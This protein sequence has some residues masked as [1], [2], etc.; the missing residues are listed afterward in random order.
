MLDSR[1]QMPPDARMLGLPGATLVCCTAGHDPAALERA[2][3]E[4]QEFDAHGD[5]VNVFE[6]LAALGE[7][8]INDV[9]VEAGPGLSGYLVEK[10]LVVGADRKYAMD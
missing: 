9:L 5:R 3:A 1:L 6:V 2:G 7:R 10:G 4:V 8:E